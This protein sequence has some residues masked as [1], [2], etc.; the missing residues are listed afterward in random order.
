ME[1]HNPLPDVGVLQA[2]HWTVKLKVSTSCSGFSGQALAGAHWILQFDR[3][4]QVKH[5]LG[6]GGVLLWGLGVHMV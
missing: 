2:V 1:Y 5:K 6:S 4:V 3:R